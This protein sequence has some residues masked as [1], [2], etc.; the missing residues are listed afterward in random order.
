MQGL[1][2]M[3]LKNAN[4][5]AAG[6]FIEAQLVTHSVFQS[7]NRNPTQTRLY[8]ANLTVWR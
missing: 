3:Q 5:C 4:A 8:E 6:F 1:A 7:L 2:L